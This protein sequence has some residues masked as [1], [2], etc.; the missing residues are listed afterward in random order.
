MDIRAYNL[1]IVGWM[2]TLF[3]L[4]YMNW[5]LSTVTVFLNCHNFFEAVVRCLFTIE[6]KL[7]TSLNLSIWWRFA[8]YISSNM[9]KCIL[10]LGLV[11]FTQ[12]NMMKIHHYNL[13]IQR[14]PDVS[15]T[16]H[17]LFDEQSAGKLSY[18]IHMRRV[19]FIPSRTVLIVIIEWK[20]L[21]I[22]STISGK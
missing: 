5:T 13:K 14:L 12:H 2:W 11:N 18:M 22:F 6:L 9:Y 19:I 1:V 3:S 16:A 8:I 15:I 7:V 20:R 10:L 21:P 4:F 17:P